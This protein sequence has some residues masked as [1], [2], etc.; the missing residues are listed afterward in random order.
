[1]YVCHCRAV[2]DWAVRSTIASGARSVADI[3]ARCPG[4]G[5]GCG[6]CRDRLQKYLDV[7]LGSGESVDTSETSSE[8]GKTFEHFASDISS[9]QPRVVTPSG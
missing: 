5:R 2:T 4:A 9:V 7:I 8:T 1:M 6:G 3:T